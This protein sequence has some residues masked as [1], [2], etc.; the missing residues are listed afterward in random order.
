MKK[1]QNLLMCGSKMNEKLSYLTICNKKH[2][3]KQRMQD[4]N[5][6]KYL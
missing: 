3:L 4:S 6:F 5:I 2:K 1:R